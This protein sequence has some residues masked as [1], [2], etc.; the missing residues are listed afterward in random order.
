[1]ELKDIIKFRR[2]QLRLTQKQLGDLIGVSSPTISR[3]ESGEISPKRNPTNSGTGSHKNISENLSKT[4][5]V[6]LYHGI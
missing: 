4:P 2:K 5:C 6:Y 3:Y 1:M